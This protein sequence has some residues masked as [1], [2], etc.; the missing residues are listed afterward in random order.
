MKTDADLLEELMRYVFVGAGATNAEVEMKLHEFR[1][2]FTMN[3]PKE[4]SDEDYAIQL[5]A[6]KKEAPAFLHHLMN[7]KFPPLP[8]GF[9]PP[10]S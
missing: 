9:L 1:T 2:I 7:S 10:N 8:P 6:M 5:T 4:L 3:P